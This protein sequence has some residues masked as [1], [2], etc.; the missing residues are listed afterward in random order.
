[1]LA[2]D[3]RDERAALQDAARE[4]A[5]ERRSLAASRWRWLPGRRRRL[6]A[7][8]VAEH[9]AVNE[10]G[11][12]DAERAHAHRPPVEDDRTFEAALQRRAEQRFERTLERDI[13]IE[14]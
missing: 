12:R 10:L 3:S 11:L 7:A 4:A 8:T 1:M 2:I 5:A 9:Q 6:E 13:G 14:R